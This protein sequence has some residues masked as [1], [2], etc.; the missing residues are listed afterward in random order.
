MKEMEPLNLLTS[1][2][3]LF[4]IGF[5]GNLVA[6]LTG[7]N[8]SILLFCG[9]LFMGATPVQVAGI[10]VTYLVFI[11][12]VVFTQGNRLSFK[13]FQIFRGWILWA[14]IAVSVAA[15]FVYPF[16]ALTL[17]LMIFLLELTV[18]LGARVPEP[19]RIPMKTRII[20]ILIG[21]ALMTGGIAL[22]TVIPPVAYM[23]AGTAV[24][25]LMCLFFWWIGNDRTRLN[26]AWD[27]IILSMF[28][29]TG[30]F[31][32]DFSE[33]LMDMHR[34]ET[35]RS[36]LTENLPLVVIPSFFI[37]MLVSNLLFNIFPIS[38]IVMVIFGALCIRLFGFYVGSGRGRMS[39]V[40]LGFTVLAVICV[41]LVNPPLTGFNNYFD[42]MASST[43]SFSWSSISALFH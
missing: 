32:F 21:S 38:G 27:S 14:A 13:N 22:T 4:N 37:A 33:W 8:V 10:M 29:L 43:A 19:L 12:L 2:L 40:A 5:F 35:T 9:L 24:A 23:Y 25:L 18:R 1:L 28:L 30:L 20:Y 15:L 16:G 36:H 41:L 39:L 7:A 11:K 26:G 17:F 31:G 6:R 42:N 3:A 34:E